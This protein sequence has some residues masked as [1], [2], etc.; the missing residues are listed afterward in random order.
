MIEVEI[1]VTEEHIKKGECCM[2][3]A[4][5]IAL[6]IDDVLADG[7]EATVGK[8][9]YGI[10]PKGDHRDVPG[11]NG[12]LPPQAEDFIAAFDFD[13]HGA[14]VKPFKFQMAI[15]PELLKVK[16]A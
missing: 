11:S 4:C 6:A 9:T 16:A 14:D 1:S 15:K 5:P 3:R 10:C 13:R 7:Y 12:N 8:H 2:C